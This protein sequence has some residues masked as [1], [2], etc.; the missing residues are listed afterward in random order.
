LSAGEIDCREG[1][2]GSTLSGY[3]NS[4]DEAVQNT[5]NEYLLSV[6]EIAY[7]F[8]VQILLMPVA[9]HAYRSEKNGKAKGRACRR[10]LM[11][12]WNSLLRE[13]LAESSG[14]GK[15]YDGVYL[16]D[17]EEELRMND[18]TSPVGFVLNKVYNADFTHMNSAFL[19]LLEDSIERCGCNLDLV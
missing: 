4:C 7:E 1:I 5:V 14:R 6:T 8:K 16:L 19:A 12:L 13:A 2:G 17:Y 18:V 3:Y 10:K 11:F 15:K 9:P